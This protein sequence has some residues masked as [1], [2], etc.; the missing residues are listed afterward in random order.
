MYR[1]SHILPLSLIKSQHQSKNNQKLIIGINY[2]LSIC[3][4]QQ[5]YHLQFNKILL[6]KLKISILLLTFNQFKHLSK[7]NHTFQQKILSLRQKISI[8]LPTLL[9]K[10][11][12]MI[13]STTPKSKTPPTTTPIPPTQL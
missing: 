1:H 4:Q 12:K 2:R 3:Q 11:H 5:K 13:F 7:L 9:Q 10:Q 8:P 6:T